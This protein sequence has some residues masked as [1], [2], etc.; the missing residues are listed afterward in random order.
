MVHDVIPSAKLQWKALMKHAQGQCK[1]F[2]TMGI[3]MLRREARC[4]RL[5]VQVLIRWFK[6]IRNAERALALMRSAMDQVERWRKLVGIVNDR[7]LEYL[8]GC[9]RL[10]AHNYWRIRQAG[11]ARPITVAVQCADIAEI[12]CSMF[13]H[14][15]VAVVVEHALGMVAFNTPS[16]RASL[17]A[18]CAAPNARRIIRGIGRS[19][20]RSVWCFKAGGTL[21]QDNHTLADCGICAGA[22]LSIRV[23]V[24]GGMQPGGG[25]A[26]SSSRSA[27][28][29]LRDDKR[30]YMEFLD[31]LRQLVRSAKGE[32]DTCSELTDLLSGKRFSSFAEDQRAEVI[33]CFLGDGRWNEH[34]QSFEGAPAWGSVK[35]KLK[36]AKRSNDK[37]RSNAVKAQGECPYLSGLH[38]LK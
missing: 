28:F 35:E 11:H 8:I 36:E 26:E 38:S 25:E 9:V 27:G 21:L 12:R 13:V 24:R 33:S 5:Q 32:S 2:A 20:S 16:S 37:K 19:Y 18:V 30:E 6:L 1:A 34:T 4:R 14:E 31:E 3:G 17:K 10:R 15:K 7:R 22:T 29:S 23:E